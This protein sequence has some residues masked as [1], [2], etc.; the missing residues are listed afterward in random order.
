MDFGVSRFSAS[1]SSEQR[2]DSDEVDVRAEDYEWEQGE[3]TVGGFAE[4]YWKVD[5]WVRRNWDQRIV[6]EREREES[7]T[8]VF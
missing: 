8:E 6:E 7:E 4:K 5:G 2:E 1:E 3:A